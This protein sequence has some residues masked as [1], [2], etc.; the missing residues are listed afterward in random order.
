VQ[1]ERSNDYKSL[2]ENPKM[3]LTE[4]RAARVF[5]EI[6]AIRQYLVLE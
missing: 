1:A 6:L 4:A 3:M 2:V 5:K